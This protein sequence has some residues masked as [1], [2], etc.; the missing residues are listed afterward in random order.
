VLAT[1]D[2]KTATPRITS[3]VTMEI[4][5]QLRPTGRILDNF[6]VALGGSKVLDFEADLGQLIPILSSRIGA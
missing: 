6:R 3:D 2:Y 4:C 5:A 1:E